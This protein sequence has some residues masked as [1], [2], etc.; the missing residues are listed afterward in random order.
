M[1]NV[2]EVGLFR[3][4]YRR[5]SALEA[6]SKK[7]RRVRECTSRGVRAETVWSFGVVRSKFDSR[8][9]CSVPR[10]GAGQSR[11]LRVTLELLRRVLESRLS[12]RLKAG[13][14]F[15]REGAVR[16]LCTGGNF[17]T[18]TPSAR[19][20][21]VVVYGFVL[22]LLRGVAWRI[23]CVGG[24]FGTAT[25]CARVTPVVAPGY[26]LQPSRGM[27]GGSRTLKF[28]SE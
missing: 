17:S 2:S 11:A 12:W 13:C 19:V 10:D 5:L 3:E 20:T 9:G 7:P 8:M 14:I 22:R 1:V 27:R 28:T 18:A 6:T 15:S 26:V 23:R 21:P 16:L 4:A 25:S 24:N